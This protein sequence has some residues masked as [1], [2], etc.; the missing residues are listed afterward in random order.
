MLTASVLVLSIITFFLATSVLA[1]NS[2]LGVNRYF[3][4]FGYLVAIWMPANYIG[5][6]F[7]DYEYAKYFIQTDFLIGTFAIYSFWLLTR[8]FYLVARPEKRKIQSY[9]TWTLLLLTVIAAASTLLPGVVN[10]QTA[11]NG[12]EIKYGPY[13]D[14]FSVISILTLLLACY[15]LFSASRHSTGRLKAQMKLMLLGLA[16]LAIFASFANFILPL[17]TTSDSANLLAGNISYLGIFTFVLA[18]FYAIVKHRLFDL[19]LAL[20]RSVGYLLSVGVVA[21]FYSILVLGIGSRFLF[22]DTNDSVTSSEMFLLLIIPT[23]FVALTF[24]RIQIYIAR[25]TRRIFYQEAYD[26]QDVLDRLSDSLITDSDMDK[27]MKNSLDVIAEAIKPSHAIFAVLDE[28]GKAY[29]HIT[30]DQHNNIDPATLVTKS[31][32]LR[33]RVLVKD[34]APTGRWPEYLEEKDISL[35]LRLG[36][37]TRPTGLL[38]FGPKQNGRIYTKQDIELLTIGAKNLAVA[39]DN[40]KKY[41]KIA[42]FADTLRLEVEKATTNLRA[43]NQK[44]KTL[45]ALK[46]DFISMASHQ[47]R[48]PASSV[49]EAIQMLNQESLNPA[50]RKRLTELAEASS[51]H[52][53]S[54][55]V[56]MLSIARIQAGHFNIDKSLNSIAELV[57][58]ALKE[59]SVL[60]EEKHIK[61]SFKQPKENTETFVDRA[62]INEAITNYIENAIK[63]SPEKT[64][65]KVNMSVKG[66]RL[67]FEVIDSGIGVPPPER[68]NLFTKFY[69]AK[70]ARTEQPDGNGIGLFVVKTVAESHDGEAYYSPQATGSLFGFWIPIVKK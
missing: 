22:S 7:K 16:M 55:V 70:N 32:H 30:S 57:K 49:H 38:F 28:A 51:E 3:A 37:V 8:E 62:K 6:N 24:H 45:D 43:A 2:K 47:L 63:Y 5:A 4:L 29:R 33:E 61:I 52:L 34:E 46:D 68:K 9:I 21:L 36:E 14:L 50:E 11:G 66:K 69:R 64:E 53:V 10:I 1:R 27:I 20:T 26:L 18:A 13:Y 15:N 39:L 12:I 56:D 54:V 60:A 31:I 25:F 42:S 19:R 40:A 65:V 58:R 17:F 48:T 59:L 67:Y 35:L 41:E 23:I 44:L